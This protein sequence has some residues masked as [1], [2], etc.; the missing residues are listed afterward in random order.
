MPTVR[1]AAAPSSPVKLRRISEIREEVRDGVLLVRVRRG[2]FAPGRALQQASLREE[3]LRGQPVV[4]HEVP[5]RALVALL[6]LQDSEEGAL[7]NGLNGVVHS[8]V[9]EHPVEQ[10]RGGRLA[11]LIDPALRVVRVA[12]I[13]VHQ[14]GVSVVDL[15]E[16]M[17]GVGAVVGIRMA[18]SRQV[19]VRLLDLLCRRALLHAQYL[20]GAAC[21]GPA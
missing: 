1:A 21:G 10:I 15:L 19:K 11:A 7:L 16:L 6:L 14:Q 12:E 8:L 5:Y 2:R 9:A 18:F 20:V 13:L 3:E 4:H 17:Q